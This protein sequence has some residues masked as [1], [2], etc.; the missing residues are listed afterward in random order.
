MSRLDDE[1]QLEYIRRWTANTRK[2]QMEIKAIR[3]AHAAGVI[4]LIS[5]EALIWRAKRKYRRAMR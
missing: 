5:M 3:E 1:E 4:S 2:L